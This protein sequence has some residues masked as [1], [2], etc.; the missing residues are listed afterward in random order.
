MIIDVHTHYMTCECWG[1]EWSDNWEPVYGSP[2]PEVTPEKY[3]LAMQDVDVAIVFGVRATFANVA[4][5]NVMISDFCKATKTKTI[6]FMA[7]DPSD[8]DVLEQMKDGIRL[9]LKGIKLYPVLAHFD[10]RDTKYDSFFIEAQKNELVILWHV[11]ATPSPHGDLS[12]SHPLIIDDVARRFP[13][14]TQI[15]AHLGHPWQRETMAVIRKN[16]RVFADI[17]AS[18]ARPFDGYHALVRAQEWSVTNK[19]LFGS[20]FPLW[21]PK[22]AMEGLYEISNLRSGNLP[23]V[24]RETIDQIINQDALSMLRLSV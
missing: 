23:Y 10:P 20:D 2:F 3:D 17:S 1:N 14:L 21:S 15:M 8:A 9:G 4:T 19:I 5:P 7:L 6:G 13:G 24:R 18:W 11:G 12:I 16:R 22:V